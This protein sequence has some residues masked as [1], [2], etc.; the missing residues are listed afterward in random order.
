MLKKIFNKK[1]NPVE[2]LRKRKKAVEEHPGVEKI[3]SDRAKLRRLIIAKQPLAKEN[4]QEYKVGCE[5]IKRIL[6]YKQ[7]NKRSYFTGNQAAEIF[8]KYPELNTPNSIKSILIASVNPDLTITKVNSLVSEI[9]S[10]SMPEKERK[11]IILTMVRNI[12]AENY[13]YLLH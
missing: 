4:K 6:K 10:K 1:K 11:S 5:W 7:E 3:K 8:K 13:D 2:E 9:F 12:K